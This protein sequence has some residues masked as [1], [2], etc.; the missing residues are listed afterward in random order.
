LFSRPLKSLGAG[1]GRGRY[2]PFFLFLNGVV[3]LR[4]VVI[5][6]GVTMSQWLWTQ[7][8][9][10]VPYD[11]WC[12]FPCSP[13][14]YVPTLS[15]Q[16][17]RYRIP[18]LF[19]PWPSLFSLWWSGFSAGLLSPGFLIARGRSAVN[20]SFG[21][22]A[23]CSPSFFVGVLVALG[24]CAISSACVVYPSVNQRYTLSRIYTRLI[25]CPPSS[26]K[27]GRV[28]CRIFFLPG[29]HP[30]GQHLRSDFLLAW[31]GYFPGTQERSDGRSS[32]SNFPGFFL[33]L[34]FEG[35][36][37]AIVFHD[38]LFNPSSATREEVFRRDL[39]AV[40]LLPLRCP[41]L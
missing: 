2:P 16:R 30:G 36:E 13:I 28:K 10:F 35:T 34:R 5:E 4:G 7:F 39:G 41:T 26:R 3:R 14:R 37:E 38:F 32:S 17:T 11:L 12:H 22:L 8:E 15:G 27:S 20:N 18:L 23:V 1:L 29:A 33:K 21:G 9:V 6:F 24:G 31:F 40:F 25:E 19:P